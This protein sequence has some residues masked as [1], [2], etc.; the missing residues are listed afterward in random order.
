[1][2]KPIPGTVIWLR[3][4]D[5][6]YSNSNE[7]PTTTVFLSENNTK[8]IYHYTYRATHFSTLAPQKH[9]KHKCIL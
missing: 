5:L 6:F 8:P 1:M 9:A 4:Y 2:K 3:T 7:E